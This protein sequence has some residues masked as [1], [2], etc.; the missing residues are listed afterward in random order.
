MRAPQSSGEVHP[1]SRPNPGFRIAPAGAQDPSVLSQCWREQVAIPRSPS[2]ARLGSGHAG[3]WEE[4]VLK[5][6]PQPCRSLLQEGVTLRAA[7]EAH[8]EDC[9]AVLASSCTGSLPKAKP[10]AEPQG[11]GQKA[12][13]TSFQQINC[14]VGCHLISGALQQ[15]PK[16]LTPKHSP[17][18]PFSHQPSPGQGNNL[19]LVPHTCSRAPFLFLFAL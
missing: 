10:F 2:P 4:A 19:A 13:S 18:G 7:R 3:S 1:P 14:P 6:R 12:A 17:S 8:S 9:H 16:C 5:W 15:H 11:A